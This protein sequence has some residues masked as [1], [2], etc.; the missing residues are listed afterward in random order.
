MYD[1]SGITKC[2]DVASPTSSTLKDNV[3]NL[4]ACMAVT[5]DAMTWNSSTFVCSKIASSTIL[6]SCQ[7]LNQMACLINTSGNIC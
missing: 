6:S 7:N 5:D 3:T 4:A 2:N 1:P